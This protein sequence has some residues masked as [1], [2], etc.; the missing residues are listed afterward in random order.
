MT[1]MKLKD[2]TR[3]DSHVIDGNIPK[4]IS[5]RLYCFLSGLYH[6]TD[7]GDFDRFVMQPKVKGE[8]AILYGNNNEIAGFTRTYKHYINQGEKQITTYSANMYLN[9]Q[10]KMQATIKNTGLQQATRER[11]ASP[12]KELAFIVFATNPLSYE[13]IYQLSDL[14]YPKPLQGIPETILETIESFK[15]QKGW[16]SSHHHPMVVNS[17]LVPLR[18]LSTEYLSENTELNEFYLSINPEYLRGNTLLAYI[19]LHLANINYGMD[20]HNEP[21][22]TLLDHYDDRQSLD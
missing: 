9:P 6:I 12:Q 4:S 17:P 3:V 8:L 1:S 18:S 2:L 13:F 14:I 20:C 22:Y 11:L 10:Y 19:P 21:P 5:H 16:R 15:K 7:P